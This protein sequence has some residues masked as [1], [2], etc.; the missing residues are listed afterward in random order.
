MLQ[1]I[2]KY[3]DY[4][5]LRHA[6]KLVIKR[7]LYV[8]D[9]LLHVATEVFVEEWSETIQDLECEA[10]DFPVIYDTEKQT[11]EAVF[12]DPLTSD[13]SPDV[14]ER[15]SEWS[16]FQSIIWEK[17]DQAF[18]VLAKATVLYRARYGGRR[19]Q[20]FITRLWKY[21]WVYGA[22]TCADML[23]TVVDEVP[24]TPFTTEREEDEPKEAYQRAIQLIEKAKNEANSLDEWFEALYLLTPWV[25]YAT[26]A[27]TRSNC[28]DASKYLR[29]LEEVM[30]D[31]QGVWLTYIL[32][33]LGVFPSDMFHQWEKYELRDLSYGYRAR[34][35]YPLFWFQAIKQHIEEG[36]PVPDALTKFDRNH[37]LS[38]YI[39]YSPI[40]ALDL[41]TKPLNSK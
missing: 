18:Q 3:Q 30:A 1:F 6:I 12:F 39:T 36:T 5:I 2:R 9:L 23:W 22:G 15:L 31:I 34:V 8:P 16:R 7:K 20:E 10:W 32:P 26:I 35:K 13:K 28:S 19:T 4:T 33:L 11:L 37:L 25:K 14:T 38:I 40:L 24:N 29:W 21:R 17:P 27:F 41:L